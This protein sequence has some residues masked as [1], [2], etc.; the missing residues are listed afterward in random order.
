MGAES[1]FDFDSRRRE[2]R[3]YLAAF[4]DAHLHNRPE[5]FVQDISDDYVNVSRGE[6]VRQTKPEI[7]AGFT[8]YLGSTEFSE[9]R[10]LGEPQIGLSK[11]G[12]AAWSIFRLRVAGT[13]RMPDGTAA[14]FDAT[15]GCLVLFE[16]RGDRWVRIAEASSRKPD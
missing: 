6:L 9:Y 3:D 11:D 15:W 2:L 10:L 7:L 4:I 12:S 1:P 16:R 8:D 13:R 5:F 14:Q